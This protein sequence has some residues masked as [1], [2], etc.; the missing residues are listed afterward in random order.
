MLVEFL[1]CVV[2][3]LIATGVL[4]ATAVLTFGEL[5]AP[6]LVVVALGNGFGYLTGL[7]LTSI[8]GDQVAYLNPAITA[9]LMA[10]YPLNKTKMN[11]LKG[12]LNMLAQVLGTAIGIAL[13]IAIVPDADK[14]NENL[15]VPALMYGTSSGS[16]FAI[17]ALGAFFLTW[18]VLAN[19]AYTLAGPRSTSTP[20]ALG[21]AMTSLQLFAFPFTTACF[22]PVRAMCL[23]LFSGTSGSDLVTF[24]SAPFVGSLIA[25]GLYL[26]AFTNTGVLQTSKSA[27]AKL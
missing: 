23:F 5:L 1:G 27:S 3:N 13:V 9:S 20:L 22:N 17:E 21:T 10:L 25:T 18:I 12:L 4:S 6:R 26:V 16:G 24:V 2:Y 19:E 7:F 11:P 8:R 14:S 15:G